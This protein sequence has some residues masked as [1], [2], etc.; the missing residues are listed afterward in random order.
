MMNKLVEELVIVYDLDEKRNTWR[1]EYLLEIFFNGI[2]NCRK[3]RFTNSQYA[4]ISNDEHTVTHPIFRNIKKVW[5]GENEELRTILSNYYLYLIILLN[6]FIL[7]HC[8]IMIINIDTNHS[9]IPNRS[10]TQRLWIKK[11]FPC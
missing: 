3:A 6:I 4:I 10:G 11:S 9:S 7:L 8:H 2:N 1:H 5:M